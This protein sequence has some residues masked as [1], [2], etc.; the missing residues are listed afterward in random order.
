MMNRYLICPSLPDIINLCLS[1]CFYEKIKTILQSQIKIC[2]VG[3]RKN[4][5]WSGWF[6]HGCTSSMAPNCRNPDAI[7]N[8]AATQFATLGFESTKAEKQ[9]DCLCDA[10]D[11]QVYLRGHN[12]VFKCSW[13][14]IPMGLVRV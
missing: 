10:E 8:G 1:S 6:H 3:L 5:F 14:M 2:V 12:S 11:N 13:F 7:S 9:V 4:N